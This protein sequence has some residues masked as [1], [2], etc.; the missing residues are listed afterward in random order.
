MAAMSRYDEQPPPRAPKTPPHLSL[1]DLRSV[2]GKT[3]E[4]VCSLV[5]DE[6]GQSFTRGALSAI[7]NGHRGASSKVLRALEIVYGLRSGA[8][9]TDYEPREWKATA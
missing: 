9:V 5:A 7:E 2:S 4:Q 6:T 8:L 1:G 3:L